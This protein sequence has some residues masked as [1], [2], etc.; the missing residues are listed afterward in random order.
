MLA[1]DELLSHLQKE[2]AELYP[3]LLN[4]PKSDDQLQGTLDKYATDM[5]TISASA[6]AFF[7]KYGSCDQK[8]GFENDCRG[9]IKVLCKRIRNEEAVL[10]KKYDELMD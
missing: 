2:D 1:R 9:L 3:V 7:D 10:Y 4:A 8:E 6:L 5:Q